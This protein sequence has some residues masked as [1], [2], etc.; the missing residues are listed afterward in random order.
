MLSYT[1]QGFVG[2]FNTRHP[3]NFVT[4]FFIIHHYVLH[5]HFGVITNN[6]NYEFRRSNNY[7]ALERCYEY[8]ICAAVRVQIVE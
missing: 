3:W 1:S 6:Y 2:S 8:L 4:L 5:S 7:I